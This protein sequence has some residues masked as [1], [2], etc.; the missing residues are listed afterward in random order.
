VRVIA[1]TNVELS[2]MVAGGAFREDLY[3]RLNV[4]AIEMPPLRLRGADI[5][6]LA[7]HF[8]SRFAAENHKA[9]EGFSERAQTKI[10]NYRWP[11]NVRE[12]ENAIER[13]VVMCE[14][15]HIGEDHLPQGASGSSS[16]EGLMIPGSTMAELE[17]VAILKTLEAVDGS[18]TR[19]AE[20][21]DISPRT[22]QY[23]LHEYGVSKERGK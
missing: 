1:A 14:G 10:R 22:I 20:M 17:K 13:A 19:A 11:G 21:L 23:R 4:V 18:T 9:I 16:L 2:R 6:A 5:L 7:D 12:L 8:L 3:Y 15:D